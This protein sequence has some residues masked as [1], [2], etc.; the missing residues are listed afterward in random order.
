M[1]TEISTNKNEH[2]ESGENSTAR[3]YQDY[4]CQIDR[5]VKMDS[6]NGQI[7]DVKKS[8][9]KYKN[10]P[11]TPSTGKIR[12]RRTFWDKFFG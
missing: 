6:Y 8:K 4:N 12:R 2:I 9:G 7:V 11:E 3:Y 10:L 1:D 5:W